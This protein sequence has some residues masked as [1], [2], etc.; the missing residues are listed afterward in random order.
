V[1]GD[2]RFEIGCVDGRA[3][4]GHLST[5]HGGFDTP[6]FM[7]V[8]TRATLKGLTPDQVAATGAR[9]VLANTYHLM[10]RPGAEVVRELGGL[11]KFMNWPAPILTDSGGFQVFSL[12]DLRRLDDHGVVFQSHIDGARIELTPEQSIDVQNQLGADIIMAFDECPAL[13]AGETEIETAVRRTVAWARRSKIAHARPDQ[14]L[15]G[16]VQGGLDA[17]WRRRCLADL[18]D[19]GFEGYAIGGLSVGEHP[20]EMWQLLDAFAHEMPPDQPRYLMGVGTPR[21]LVEAVFAGV[22]QFDCVMPTRNGR[23]SYAFTSEGPVRLRNA[24]HKLSKAP[25]D[26][27]CDCYTCREFSRGYLRHLFMTGEVL[28][29]TLVSMHNLTFYQTLMSRLRSAIACGGLDGFRRDFIAHDAQT[30]EEH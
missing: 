18:V 19:I 30:R 7:P 13:P 1:A 3:R 15:Y 9:I 14:A 6:A 17:S 4:C 26:P 22:D 12:A 8:G 25:L 29:A 5:P 23:K 24:R 2:L 28:G 16:I 20:Q 21:D 27:A 10:L 11:H